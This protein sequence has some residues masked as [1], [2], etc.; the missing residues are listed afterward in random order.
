MIM[1]IMLPVVA[2]IA[3]ASILLSSSLETRTAAQVL[4]NAIDHSLET[5][6]GIHLIQV[7]TI[8]KTCRAIT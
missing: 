3:K 7:G 1:V 5:A 4:Q 6:K 8:N 2:L